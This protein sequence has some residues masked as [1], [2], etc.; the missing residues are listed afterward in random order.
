VP[1]S[2]LDKYNSE[3]FEILGQTGVIDPNDICIQYKGGRPYITRK[4]NVCPYFNK[5]EIKQDDH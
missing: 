3:Q 1:I 4:K 2:F 5:E